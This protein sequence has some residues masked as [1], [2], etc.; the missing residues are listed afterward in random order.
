M[1]FLVCDGAPLRIVIADSDARVRSAIGMLLR[2]EPGPLW[3]AEACD[4][5]SPILHV[6]LHDPDMVLLDW[7]L[8]GQP[9]AAV[10]LALSGVCHRSRVIVLNSP[11]GAC[12]GAQAASAAVAIVGKDQPPEHLLEA[13]RHVRTELYQAQQALETGPSCS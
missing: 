10:L 7:G 8:P 1:G 13:F 12:T 2:Q 11:A 3:I 6:Q 4:L 9:A 5:D